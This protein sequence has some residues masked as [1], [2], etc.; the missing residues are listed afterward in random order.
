MISP[1]NFISF[2]SKK[3]INFSQYWVW[4]PSKMLVK[5]E[6]I[7]VDKLELFLSYGF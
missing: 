4:I 1:L 6:Q 3:S 2:E 5:I 7:L